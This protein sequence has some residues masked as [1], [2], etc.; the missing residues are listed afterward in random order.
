MKPEQTIIIN[1]SSIM[2]DVENSASWKL[3][4]KIDPNGQRSILCLTKMDQ[5]KEKGLNKRINDYLNKKGFIDEDNF[6]MI[7]NGTQE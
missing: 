6:F 5:Y 3:S 7:R 2:V 1:I 4:K